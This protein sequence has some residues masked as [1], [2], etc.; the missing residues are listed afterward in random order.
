MSTTVGHM[1]QTKQQQ[2]FLVHLIWQHEAIISFGYVHQ[3]INENNRVD[4]FHLFPT[5]SQFNHSCY[6]NAL[7][8]LVGNSA[9][10]QTIKPIKTG[11]EITISNFSRNSAYV[12]NENTVLRN[13]FDISCPCDLCKRRTSDESMKNDPHFEAIFGLKTISMDQIKQHAFAF[14]QKFG[15]SNCIKVDRVI[16]RL[17]NVIWKQANLEGFVQLID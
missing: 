8:Y 6:P 10:I 1:F 12:T 17:S 5:H 14:L 7:F 4:S 13:I 2:R 9:V 11:E 3:Y 15:R 16:E